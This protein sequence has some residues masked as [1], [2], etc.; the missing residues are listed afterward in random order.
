MAFTSGTSTDY[1]DLLADFRTWI[2]GTAGWTENS[3]TASHL[4]AKTVD[5]IAAGGSGYAVDDTITLTGGTFTVAV[6][7]TVTSV[8]SG[9][10]TGVDI[11]TAGNYTVV[12]GNPVSQGST[13]GSGTGAT[14]NLSFGDSAAVLELEGPGNG[15][16]ARV[17][18]NIQTY[19]DGV[20]GIYSWRLV[21]ATGWA[22]GVDHL[23][24]QGAGG[25]C[26]LNLWDASIDYWFYAND[27]R[28][29]IVA[30]VSTNYM[31]CYCGFGSPNALPTEYPFPLVMIASYDTPQLPGLANAANSFI[32]DP[33][34]GAAHYRKRSAE[35]WAEI[36]NHTKSATDSQP[37]N[38]ARAFVWPHKTGVAQSGGT[39][40]N[41]NWS[42]GA[43]LSM[44][45]NFEDEMPLFQC[46]V[47]DTDD[48]ML[49]VALEG[50]FST[51]GF[52]RS[53]EQVVTV[54][55]QDYRLFQRVFRSSARDFMAIE[56]T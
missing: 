23:S 1:L 14:F 15:A 36:K 32:A 26:Y 10:V 54:S 21:G 41:T 11:T 12:P 48:E 27:R 7:L 6:V 34:E 53:V 42:N 22:S 35:T 56:E 25:L 44:R 38:G 28:F 40:G 30:Q 17:Y 24:Q 39:D 13:S 45:P 31:S 55:A 4:E 18:V 2:T 8:S 50:V 20:G 19:W 46:H 29:I 37:A 3:Y 52:N 16:S 33:G 51:G 49:V 47:I 5:S 9:A 43:F